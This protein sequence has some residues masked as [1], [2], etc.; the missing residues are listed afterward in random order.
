[1]KKKLVVIDLDHTLIGVDSFR[2]YINKKIKNGSFYALILKWLRR[3]RFIRLED[4]KKY[5]IRLILEEDP[6][7]NNLT[8]NLTSFLN[9]P[10]LNKLKSE[11]VG[12]EFELL[13]LSASPDNYVR[14]LGER[15]QINAKGS[16]FENDTKTFMHIHGKGKIDYLLHHFPKDTYNYEYAISD[17]ITD[18]KLLSLFKKSELIEP[19]KI[20]D[21]K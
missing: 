13:I 17:S 3:F 8:G 16:H 10:L 1:M 18:E 4:F 2:F 15:L 5:T 7:L 14:I 12:D 6:E 9:E 20:K 19:F 11:F 21:A